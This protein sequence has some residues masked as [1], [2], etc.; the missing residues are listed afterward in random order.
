MLQTSHLYE[1][2]PAYVTDQPAFLNAACVVHTSLDMQALLTFVKQIEADSKRT[3]SAQRY[4]PRTLDIDLILAR[5]VCTGAA[6][7]SQ[8]SAFA[9]VIL[10]PVVWAVTLHII[11]PNIDPMSILSNLD[12]LSLSRV[13]CFSNHHLIGVQRTSPFPVY[14]VR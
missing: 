6:G 7:V 8:I 14:L 9:Y 11:R 3:P 5:Y 4:G 12:G 13:P 1:T 10:F 2:G